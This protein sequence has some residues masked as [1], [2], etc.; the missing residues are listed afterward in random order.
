MEVNANFIFLLITVMSLMR[1]ITCK[2][3]F[4]KDLK[5]DVQFPPVN[6]HTVAGIPEGHLRPLGKLIS[7]FVSSV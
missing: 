2:T 6:V 3:S 1:G 5:T 4:V 7:F